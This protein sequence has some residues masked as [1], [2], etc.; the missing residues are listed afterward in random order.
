MRTRSFIFLACLLTIGI[1]TFAFFSNPNSNPLPVPTDGT[2]VLD[3]EE[4]EGNQNKREEWF[5][6]MHRTAP[7]T[8]WRKLEYLNLRLSG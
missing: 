6:L 2:I 3:K 1:C 4:D 7:D 8:D 5:E